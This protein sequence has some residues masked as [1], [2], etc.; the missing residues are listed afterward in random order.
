MDEHVDKGNPLI[1]IAKAIIRLNNSNLKVHY[2]VG[3]ILQK[4]INIFKKITKPNI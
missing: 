2:R 1:E 4:V 3:A